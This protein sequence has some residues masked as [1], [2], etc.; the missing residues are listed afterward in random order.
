MATVAAAMSSFEAKIA[1]GPA[2]SM[3]NS[4]SAASRPDR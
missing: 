1:E 2:G 4:T 3:F